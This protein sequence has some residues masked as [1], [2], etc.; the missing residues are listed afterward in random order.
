MTPEDESD[1]LHMH[2]QA[3]FEIDMTDGTRIFGKFGASHILVR[4]PSMG[5]TRTT[6]ADVALAYYDALD[7]FCKELMCNL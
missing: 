4:V 3:D 2:M 1:D 5:E 6:P 7:L